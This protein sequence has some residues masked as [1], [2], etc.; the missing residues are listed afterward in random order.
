MLGWT[1][2]LAC[3]AFTLW[4]CTLP[5]TPSKAPQRPQVAS[6]DADWILAPFQVVAGLAGLCWLALA[7]LL[8]VSPLLVLAWLVAQ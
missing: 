8:F 2:G 6:T 3:I 7:A 4:G 5:E 1:L